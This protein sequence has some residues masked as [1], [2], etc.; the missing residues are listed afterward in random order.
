M[1]TQEMILEGFNDGKVSIAY[2]NGINGCTGI[3][4]QIGE[5]SFYFL[6]NNEM[7]VKEYWQTYNMPQTLKLLHGVLKTQYSAEMNGIGEE[8]WKYY[9]EQLTK[10]VDLDKQYVRLHISM[11]YTFVGDTGIDIPKELL[12]GKS[13][14]EQYKIAYEYALDNIDRI[15]VADNAEYI[16]D[17]DTFELEDIDFENNTK[18]A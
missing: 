12:E 9:K 6:E 7:S 10:I 18:E 14:D 17:S 1:I 8:E 15:P 16:P 2:G 3:Y 13:L 5:H 11:A 4:C